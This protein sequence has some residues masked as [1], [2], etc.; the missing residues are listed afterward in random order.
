[1]YGRGVHGLGLG[2]TWTQF[3]L[4]GGQKKGLVVD[5]R[6][7]TDWIKS[8]GYVSRLVLVE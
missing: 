5:W 1:M 7:E 8:V 6:E 4:V 2:S 3:D